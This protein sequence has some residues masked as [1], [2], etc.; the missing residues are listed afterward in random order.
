MSEERAS[1]EVPALVTHS[2]QWTFVRNRDG[3]A[4]NVRC[5]RGTT[6]IEVLHRGE[7]VLVDVAEFAPIDIAAKTVYDR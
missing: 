6:I 4:T 7:K 2:A 1:Y 5:L 3:R